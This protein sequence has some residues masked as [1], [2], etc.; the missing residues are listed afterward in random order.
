MQMQTVGS[1]AVA[2]IDEDKTRRAGPRLSSV[3]NSLS[4]RKTGR[5]RRSGPDGG[6]I[7]VDVD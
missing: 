4:S 1:S 7:F 2:V 6:D 3:D 5:V